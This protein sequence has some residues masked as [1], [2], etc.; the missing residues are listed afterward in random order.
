MPRARIHQLILSAIVRR[1]VVALALAAFLP[2]G[3]IGAEGVLEIYFIDTEG[4]QA[5]LLVSP[6]GGTLLIDTGF[7][8]LDTANPD[9]ESGRD[10]ARIAEV[11]KIAGARQI[12]VLLATHFHG[13]H[14]GGVTNL[15]A[16]LPI[17]MFVDHGPAV[18]DVPIM[19]Q[20]VGSYSEPWAEAFAKAQHRAVSAGDTIGVAGLEVTVVQALGKSFERT[21]DA[22]PAC[23]GVERR[24]DGNPEDTASVGVVIAYGRFRFANFG[25]LPWNQEVQLLCPSN[26]VGTIDVY[27]SA[28]HG[29][30]PSPGVYGMAPRVVVHDNG[31]RKG[32][33]PV[34]L[35]AFRGSPGIEDIW[36]LHKNIPGGADG[37]PPD[38]F[39]ANLQD[40]D[41]T[42]HP[43][44]Y[45]KLSAKDDGSFSMFNSRTRMTKV[46]GARHAAE[47]R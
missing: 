13:D 21:G 23:L 17:R 29:G 46:Y 22:N 42:N 5:T 44:H 40:T 18:Q 37:N 26:R 20:K 9:K 27:Q 35:K 3:A 24:M 6:T 4:G 16:A 41:D 38:E 36:Q 15:V 11:A 1:L 14:A 19:R 8:G 32:G 28:R 45:L 47:A 25:D 12:D 31:A 30:E 7:A 2:V 34:A 10:A 43:A 33:G 39:S